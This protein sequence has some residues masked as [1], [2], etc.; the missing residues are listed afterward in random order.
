[1]RKSEPDPILNNI[2]IDVVVDDT[3]WYTLPFDCKAHA[4]EVLY[5][6]LNKLKLHKTGDPLEI[7]LLLA[8]N[9][10][11]QALNLDF[12]AIDKPTN[13]LSF[14]YIDAEEF[15]L[16][17]VLNSSVQA[18][19]GDIAI[20]YETIAQEAN[21][22]DKSF[23]SHFTHMIIHGLLHLLGYDHIVDEEREVMEFLEIEILRS[24]FDITNPFN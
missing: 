9:S 6:V 5:A 3:S 13:V 22:Q 17:K 11:L 14:P 20:G 18:Y 7:S 16:D 23:K 12:R 19:L 8:N 4:E 1:M 21:D 24:S 2:I 10:R 15:D